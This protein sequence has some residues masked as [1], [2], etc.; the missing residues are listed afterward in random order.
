MKYKDDSKLCIIIIPEFSKVK[1]FSIPRYLVRLFLSSSLVAA[2]LLTFFNNRMTAFTNSLEIENQD[3]AQII[4]ELEREV[5]GLRQAGQDKDQVISAL[6]S[7]SLNVESQVD[8]VDMVLRDVERLQKELEKK[9]GIATASRSKELV[10]QASLENLKTEANLESLEAMLEVKEK[11]LNNFIDEIDKRFKYL[12]TVPDRWPASGRLTSRYGNRRDPFGRG[13]R[14]HKGIDLAN[15]YGSNIRAAA[16]GIVTYSASRSG[17]GRTI[18][19]KHNSQYETLYAHNS[20]NLVRV[21]DR[22]EKGQ[23]IAKMG[24]SG[25]ATGCH[26]HFEVHKDGKT[27]NPL[28]ILK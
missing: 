26:L 24:T 20:R 27:M 16:S 6:E 22:V 17:Y 8:Q 25:R 11:E 10:R 28:S 15:S 4:Y 12:D 18:V 14:F 1:S 21:G 2:F 19:I 9:A 3:K 13:T 23:V 7:S 5:Q